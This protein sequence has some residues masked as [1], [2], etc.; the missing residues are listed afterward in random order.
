M[1]DRRGRQADVGWKIVRARDVHRQGGGAGGSADIAVGSRDG[2]SF[3][4]IG[5]TPI[6]GRGVGYIHIR[7]TNALDV[8]RAVGA[9]LGHIVSVCADKG[10]ATRCAPLNAVAGNTI[11][12]CGAECAGLVA[13]GVGG[14]RVRQS[15]GCGGGDCRGLIAGDRDGERLFKRVASCIG[16]AHPN[17]ITARA[18]C[19]GV[20]CNK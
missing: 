1:V 5:Q 8:Q 3:T 6:D 18:Q 7:P 20:G 11:C 12:V 2:E 10:A 19:I 9:Q 14:R 17:E 15:N 4:G 16:R 13:E